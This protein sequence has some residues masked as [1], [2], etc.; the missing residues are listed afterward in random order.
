MIFIIPDSSRA[1]GQL[2]RVTDH[3]LLS[4]SALFY[5]VTDLLEGGTV[6]RAKQT[7]CADNGNR[8]QAILDG[9]GG[10]ARSTKC[11]SGAATGA[12][13]FLAV[14]TNQVFHR[15]N[16]QGLDGF[17]GYTRNV[18]DRIPEF[19]RRP[20]RESDEVGVGHD[21]T[22]RRERA[23]RGTVLQT[24]SPGCSTLALTQAGKSTSQLVR[25]LSPHG[26]VPETSRA[27]TPL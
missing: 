16:H 2:D 24:L 6:P 17:A 15:F 20:K 4:P 9:E 19:G 8:D 1:P 22:A 25:P 10:I 7:G 26:W 11:R 14:L 13:G 5:G 23:S 3:T 12:G 18:L 27:R 21:F